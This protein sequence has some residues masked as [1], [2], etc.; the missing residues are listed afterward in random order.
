MMPRPSTG[1]ASTPSQS[2]LEGY[3]VLVTGGAGAIGSALVRRL[4]EIGCARILALDDLS[5]GFSWLVPT[6]SRICLVQ[7]SVL[8]RG[9][10]NEVFSARPSVVFHLAALFANLNS[11]EHP[12]QDLLVN[13]LG[14]LRVLQSALAN[15][16][17]RVVLASTSSLSKQMPSGS[18][19]Q[20]E[21]AIISTPYQA[22][23]LLA[24]HYAALFRRDGVL[25]TVT[26]RLFN[27]YGP[28]E[29][30]GLYRNVIPNFVYL[31]LRG[32]PLPIRG[33]GEQ[34]RDF[35]YIDDIVDGFIRAAVTNRV[36][37]HPL[38]IGTGIETSIA[39]LAEMVNCI[40]G[41]RAGLTPTVAH[42]WD[43]QV[44]R[45]ASTQ[46][47]E[48][49]LEYR[50]RF[51]LNDGLERTVSWFRK[52]WSVIDDCRRAR[53]APRTGHCGTASLARGNHSAEER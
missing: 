37:A 1:L 45:R 22:T 5:S 23:K 35:T 28:G 17:K 25:S 53:E 39:E 46:E 26:L 41:N 30:P 8:D 2:G 38:D 33:S 43:T 40:T 34:T 16:T 47:A 19:L 3:T 42:S 24:E 14:T 51:G 32:L 13:G 6:H 31:A 48:R 7:T 10:M 52:H 15:N 50:S 36:A 49:I 27:S 12:E 20:T 9:A 21:A 4:A 11:I 29:V 18:P 44:R